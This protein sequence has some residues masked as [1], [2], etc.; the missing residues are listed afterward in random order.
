MASIVLQGVSRVFAGGTHAVDQVDLEVRDQEFFVLVGP[1][2]CGKTTTLRMIAGIEPVTSGTI[3]L[4]G[5]LVNQLAA[6]D[7][8]LA[9]VV[10]QDALYPH[11]TVAGNLAFGWRLRTGGWWRR[12]WLWLVDRESAR[13][14]AAE[15][16]SIQQR[17]TETARLLGMSG[18]L[19][20][21]PAQLSGGERQRVALGRALIRQPQAF[22]L[23]EPLSS[24]DVPL[25]SQLRRELKRIQRRLAT[26]ILWVTHDQVEALTLGD[27]IAVM[28]AGV[29]QQVGSPAEV[30]ERPKNRFVAGF[31]GSP[32]MSFLAGRL[33]RDTRPN[34]PSAT[35]D[36]AGQGPAERWQLKTTGWRLALGSELP[37]GTRSRGNHEVLIGIRPEHVR[38]ADS[39][40]PDQPGR[41]WAR[42]EEI[43]QLGDRLV[44]YFRP[45]ADGQGASSEMGAGN[46]RGKTWADALAPV[47]DSDLIGAK[48][49]ETTQLAI[50]QTVALEVDLRRLHWFDPHTGEN[51]GL[52][53]AS[54]RDVALDQPA[55]HQGCRP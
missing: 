3:H 47:G 31:I 6:R 17:V 23:D 16:R 40:E 46:G 54:G 38:L 34:E 7:R 24:L 36:A 25:R 18:L 49:A 14:L 33:E 21:R 15:R 28:D 45:L 20:R 43:E 5:V 9:M 13:R 51:I 12:C 53:D 29:I 37:R 50:G 42:V 1:S 22:L 11:L 41:M 26:T 27:R 19:D 52:D 2:G 8:N 35:Q 4:G 30:Y 39:F 55:S 48:L 32:A 44:A 10:Q